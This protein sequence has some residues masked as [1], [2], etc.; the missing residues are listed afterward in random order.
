MS[1][2]YKIITTKNGHHHI[3]FPDYLL[4]IL[5]FDIKKDKIQFCFF[6]GEILIKKVD[7]NVEE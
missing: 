6:N 2:T 4:E 3:T 5:N 1:Q 7:R